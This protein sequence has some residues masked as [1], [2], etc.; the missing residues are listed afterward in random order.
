MRWHDR[1]SPN[2]AMRHMAFIGAVGFLFIGCSSDDE[3]PFVTGTVEGAA[4]TAKGAVAVLYP[5]DTCSTGP[6]LGLTIGFDADSDF[7]YLQENRCALRASSREFAIAIWEFVSS[8]QIEP[9]TY[10]TRDDAGGGQVVYQVRF[11]DSCAHQVPNLLS[12]S[13]EVIL[14]S[15]DSTHVVGSLDVKFPAGGNLRGRFDAAVIPPN[16]GACNSLGMSGGSD[17][18][19][20]AQY[21]CLR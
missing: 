14:D 1:C 11:D 2:G 7:A 16:R 3:P 9:G 18:S 5:L 6:M 8:G 20:C 15:V 12:S 17:L 13:G 19:V 10:P 21:V 4:F